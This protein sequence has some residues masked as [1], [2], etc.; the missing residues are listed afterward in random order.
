LSDVVAETYVAGAGRTSGTARAGF[1]LA[2]FRF[3]YRNN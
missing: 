2:L 1:G 3:D